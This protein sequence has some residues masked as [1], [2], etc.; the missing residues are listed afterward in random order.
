MS[1]RTRLHPG[2]DCENRQFKL[3][4]MIDRCSGSITYTPEESASSGRTLHFLTFDN[5]IEWLASLCLHARPTYIFVL[6]VEV[7][8]L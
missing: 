2:E 7:E 3:C 8:F 5:R 4:Y 1:L 6:A